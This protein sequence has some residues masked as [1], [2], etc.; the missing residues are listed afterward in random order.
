MWE[1]IF[2]RS[3][4]RTL[5]EWRWQVL[6]GQKPLWKL[7]FNKSSGGMKPLFPTKQSCQWLSS[8]FHPIIPLYNKIC[9][10]VQI[11]VRLKY[12]RYSALCETFSPR[13]FVTLCKEGQMIWEAWTWE[14]AH[15]AK[16]LSEHQ[17]RQSPNLPISV[18]SVG[19]VWLLK[20]CETPQLLRGI[21]NVYVSV[22][23]SMQ[24]MTISLGACSWRK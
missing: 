17:R 15:K 4:D 19:F 8:A 9:E 20:V 16:E 21:E 24:C 2:L 1:S 23:D 12:L 7:A 14:L 5:M 11:C 22:R 13:R 3:S 10:M 18:R 6:C